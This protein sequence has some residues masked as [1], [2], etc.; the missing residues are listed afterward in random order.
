MAGGG[1]GL[2]ACIVCVQAGDLALVRIHE[3]LG[4]V[5]VAVVLNF[6]M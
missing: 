4:G 1:G 5:I 2:W 3:G 6:R